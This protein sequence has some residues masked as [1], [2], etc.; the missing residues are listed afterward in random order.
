M[1]SA[2]LE[3]EA[4]AGVVYRSDHRYTTFFA[5]RLDDSCDCGAYL[6]IP[7]RRIEK[8]LAMSRGQQLGPE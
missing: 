8:R 2:R 1:R 5:D 7:D 6:L 3:G 4:F